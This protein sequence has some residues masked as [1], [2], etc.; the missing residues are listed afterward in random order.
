MANSYRPRSHRKRRSAGR[1]GL[2]G[3]LTGAAGIAVVAAGIAVLQPDGD[4]GGSLAG[5]GGPASTPS[6]ATGRPLTFTTPEGYGYRLAAVKTGVD[7][8]PFGD[9]RP[10]PSGSTYAY[11]D[12]VITNTGQRPVLLDY[13]ADLFMPRSGVPDSARDRC[14]PQPGIPDSMC[15]LPN[16]SKV[17]AR[18]EG[19][20]PPVRDGADTL[21][22]AG[23]SYVVRVASDLP[24]EDDL[25]PSDL[26]LYVWNARYT[27]DR[28][29]VELALP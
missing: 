3:A 12:Y 14:M 21:I 6:P 10:P 18:L 23:A 26:R 19:S 15:T 7:P 11:A 22:P 4:G 9:G 8:R 29:G 16:S 25:D 1:V 2:A 5:E 17:T 27:S 13:P 28:K 24:V 20:K